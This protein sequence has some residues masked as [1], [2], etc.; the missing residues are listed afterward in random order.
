MA[1]WSATKKSDLE[2]VGQGQYLQK[3]LSRISYERF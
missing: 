1:L 3:S 2:N